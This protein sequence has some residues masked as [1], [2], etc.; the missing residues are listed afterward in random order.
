MLDAL[1]ARL[2]PLVAQQDFGWFC[3][4]GAWGV[5]GVGEVWARRRQPGLQRW[6]VAV[7]VAQCA[8]AVAAVARLALPAADVWSPTRT[9]EI[10]AWAAVSL[11]AA[12][13]WS[14]AGHRAKWPGMAVAVALGVVQAAQPVVLGQ[15][16]PIGGALGLAAWHALGAWSARR[17]VPLRVG[18]LLS[19]GVAWQPDGGVAFLV[20]EAHRWTTLSLLAWP[21]ALA[22][23]AAAGLSW[24]DCAIA[25]GLRGRDAAAGAIRR[26]GWRVAG[27]LLVGW[28]LAAVS[29]G[30]ARNGF[31]KSLL[32]RA[33][34]Y[35]SMLDLPGIAQWMQTRFA[36]GEYLTGRNYASRQIG[37]F[38][39]PAIQDPAIAPTRDYLSRLEAV[40]RSLD[41]VHLATLRDD[42][43]VGMLVAWDDHG[44]QDR[45][46]QH[47]P[48]RDSDRLAW[49][50][51]ELFF[52]PPEKRPWGSLVGAWAPLEAP[53]GRMLGWL[54]LDVSVAKWTAVQ[55]QARLQVLALIGFGLVILVS[56]EVSRARATR[57][58]EAERAA[59]LAAESDRTK[60]AFLAQVSHELRTPLQSILGYNELLRAHCAD[61][62]QLR[63]ISAQT[64]HGE[65]L[66]RLVNDL[67]DAMSLQKGT[68]SLRPVPGD[69]AAV[70]RETVGSLR[71]R[72]ADHGVLLTLRV[73]PAGAP[74][75]SFDPERVRQVVQNLVGNAIKFAGVGE[76]VVTLEIAAPAE[77]GRLCRLVVQDRGP[78][79][80]PEH[81]ARLF[82]PFVRI[83][84][85]GKPKEGAGLGLAISRGLSAAMGGDL[86]L[87]SDGRS[88]CTFTATW[89]FEEPA[90]AATPQATPASPSKNAL[91]G[92]RI[93]VADDNFLVRDYLREALH[94]CGADV[95][96]A[97]DGEA[98]LGLLAEAEFDALVIDLSMPR[99][100]G[101]AAVRILRQ[102]NWTGRVVGVSAHADTRDH[103]RAVEAGMDAFLS[104]PVRID[105]LV[106]ALR[107]VA[108][109]TPAAPAA[110]AEAESDLQLEAM[111]QQLRQR[112]AAEAV[113][114]SEALGEQ[115][116]RQE[117]TALTRELHGLRG[118]ATM[119]G[120]AELAHECAEFEAA[121]TTKDAPRMV[122]GS[123]RVRAGLVTVSRSPFSSAVLAQ[124]SA[125]SENRTQN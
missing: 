48:A 15:P 23:L 54:V 2:D 69:L 109:R 124:V 7:A 20:D 76:V 36:L 42:Q 4:L 58:A 94:W 63:W 99:M 39:V 16:T 108:S 80:A 52:Q 70:L 77:G 28:V 116:A 11:Q 112:F 102:R 25:Q 1:H 3:V 115:V 78:G 68:F 106:A 9:W 89:R 53:D 18:L 96:T 100:D 85:A 71:L 8:L 114:L 103:V 120:Y 104:K 12:T 113:R 51:R 40:D 45:I 55:A 72:A 22:G 122:Q 118:A 50:R 5:L 95:V 82:Q 6:L 44:P 90:A 49:S 75:L 86:T 35:R 60:T 111:R 117:W 123:K 13:M 29:G 57:A 101:D 110:A 17:V 88:G 46:V 125:T 66:L 121:I 93:L 91:A 92:Q 59:M 31:E 83:A 56:A 61:P 81:Q 24:P 37:M 84:S 32:D 27:W 21:A 43:V 79:I 64:S 105:A 30:L 73:P 47:R 14:Q 38:R 97:A 74:P 62:Q 26:L 41:K 119:L 98:A 87:A 19:L 34:V 67:L 33:V 65:L 10:M 107:G